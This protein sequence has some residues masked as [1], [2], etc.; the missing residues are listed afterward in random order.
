MMMDIRS[1]AGSS[2]P[3]HH[4]QGSE[5]EATSHS[6]AGQSCRTNTHD[7]I[8]AVVATTAAA[9][10][11]H[12]A[13]TAAVTPPGAHPEAMLEDVHQL[14]HNPPGPDAS[15]L[16][17]EQCHHDVDQLIVTTIN[18]MLCGGWQANRPSGALVLF[19]ADSCSLAAQ[20]APSAPHA[21]AAS[22]ATTDMRAKL[23][24]H[25]SGED[26]RITIEHR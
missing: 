16:V 11:Q 22:V 3:S 9:H 23:E 12:S 4:E 13:A 21:L 1:I 5:Q 14:L 25:R 2:H 17:A 15:P 24:R 26:G 18:T 8:I 10:R 7:T 19:A 6:R 20:R